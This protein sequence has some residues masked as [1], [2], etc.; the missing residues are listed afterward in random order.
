M[1]KG[2]ETVPDGERNIGRKTMACLKNFMQFIASNITAV[3]L[4]LSHGLHNLFVMVSINLH[5]CIHF[6]SKRA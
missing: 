3:N 5:M 4:L 1:R 6:G 2:R